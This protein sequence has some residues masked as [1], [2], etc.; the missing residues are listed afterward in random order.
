[1]SCGGLNQ[2]LTFS[3][4]GTNASDGAPLDVS[5]LVAAKTIFLAGTYI[6]NY[7]ILGSHD[8]VNY[9]PVLQ[10]SGGEGPQ[11]IRRDIKATLRF[12]KVH[13]N[14]NKGVVINLAAQSTCTC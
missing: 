14:A 4:P 9:V 8:G 10:F 3:V 11:A 7:I 1:M 2:F 6:G 5:G 12:M 13:R